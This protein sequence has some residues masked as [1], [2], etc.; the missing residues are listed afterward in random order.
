MDLP[1]WASWALREVGQREVAGKASNPRIIEYRRIGGCEL[2]GE[3]SAVPW[4]AIFVNAA[5]R[6]SGVAGTGNAMARGFERSKN[7]VKLDGPAL[8]AIVTYWRDSPKSGLGHVNIYL[9]HVGAGD[10]Q[11]ACV[12]GNQSDA[13]SIANYGTSRRV[14]YYWP[15]NVPL[16][17]IGRVA[18]A[19]KAA[20]AAEAKEV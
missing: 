5:L 7:F 16:P 6:A 1:R 18:Y 19:G 17:K 9:G 11:I 20:L 12:G 2:P 8:G 3:D 15:V 10:A 13:V 14:G 4:C